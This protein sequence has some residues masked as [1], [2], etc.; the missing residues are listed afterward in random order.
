MFPEDDSSKYMIGEPGRKQLRV[1]DK[2]CTVEFAD[3]VWSEL[4]QMMH[5]SVLT[6]DDATTTRG[7]LLLV[8]EIRKCQCFWLMFAVDDRESLDALERCWD[9]IIEVKNRQKRETGEQQQSVPAI[10]LVGNKIDLVPADNVITSDDAVN[11]DNDS[12]SRTRRRWVTR[13]EAT[14]F[15]RRGAYPTWSVL[16]RRGITLRRCSIRL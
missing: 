1:D 2:L 12:M 16:P 11:D 13:R 8:N 3:F 7:T 6:D 15:A 4:E 5:S 9:C 14:N 10:M